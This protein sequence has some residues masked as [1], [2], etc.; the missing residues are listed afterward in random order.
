[1]FIVASWSWCS[2]SSSGGH[3]HWHALNLNEDHC[4]ILLGF[5]FIWS[6]ALIMCSLNI[7]LVV[8]FCL[9]CWKFFFYSW[10]YAFNMCSLNIRLVVVRGL[11]CFVGV[12]LLHMAIDNG[13]CLICMGIIALSCLSFI[14]TCGCLAIG[15]ICLVLFYWSFTS[16][17]ATVWSFSK[18]PWPVLERSWSLICEMF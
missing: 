13:M 9:F 10:H 6:Y 18:C 8:L 2:F 5:I 1:M 16:Y 14:S 17:Y 3:W 12:F 7:R 11:P 4:R 15:F